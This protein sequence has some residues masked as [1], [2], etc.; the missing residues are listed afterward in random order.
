MSKYPDRIPYDYWINSQLSIV[1]FSGCCTLNG[2]RYECDYDNCK[3]E[4]N[5]EGETMYFPDL[6]KVEVNDE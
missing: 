2:D 1:R 6:V 4:I 3:T 5:D